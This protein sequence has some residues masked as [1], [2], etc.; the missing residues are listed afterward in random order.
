MKSVQ[1]KDY[2]LRG[3]IWWST[4]ERYKERF[5]A[6]WNKRFWMIPSGISLASGV[7]LVA[8]SNALAHGGSHG[9][10][11]SSTAPSAE[12][13][14]TSPTE[15]A[16]SDSPDQASTD[17]VVTDNEVSIQETPETQATASAPVSRAS[18]SE[19]FSLGI[20][21]SLLGLLIAGPFLLISLKKRIQSK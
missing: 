14:H 2:M 11:A 4:V 7:Q 16:A 9:E 18:V 6:N 19:G 15:A 10:D 20:G 21:E 8:G 13:H 17:A 5:V 1:H 12:E 3:I